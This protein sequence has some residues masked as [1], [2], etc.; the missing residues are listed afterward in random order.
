[1]KARLLFLLILPLLY[2]LQSCDD[3]KNANKID[4]ETTVDVMG[5]HFISTAE[6]AGH[7]EIAAAKVAV[8]NSKNQQVIDFAKMMISD[9]TAAGEK[10]N[11]L[12]DIELVRGKFPVD[13]KH[14]ELI[15]SL[16]RLSGND[17]DKAYMRFMVD[18]HWDAVALFKRGSENRAEDVQ[19]FA[20]KTLPTVE[21]H[22]ESA[23]NILAS[24]K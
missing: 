19:N 6:E 13:E 2:L 10:L 17:F 4:N 9:H 18:S 24:L 22:F 23:K 12:K 5:L 20:E 14:Q 21:K 15:D 8:N 16:A 3:P 11:H 7:T 1:M